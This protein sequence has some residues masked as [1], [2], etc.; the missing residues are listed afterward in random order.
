MTFLILLNGMKMPPEKGL[1]WEKQ[2]LNEEIQKP[3]L[4]NWKVLHIYKTLFFFLFFSPTFE[5]SPALKVRLP[6]MPERNVGK[7][8]TN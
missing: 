6:P 2:R 3:L 1:N 8:L 4:V 7:H 5:G